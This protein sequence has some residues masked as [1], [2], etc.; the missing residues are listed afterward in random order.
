LWR[1]ILQAQPVLA[2]LPGQVNLNLSY[3]MWGARNPH[4]LRYSTPLTASLLF[5]RRGREILPPSQVPGGLEIAAPLKG[6]VA[7]ECVSAYTAA[8]ET[9]NQAL[10]ETEDGYVGEEGEVWY[11]LDE[12]GRWTMLK[13]KPELIEAVHWAASGIN[14]NAIIATCWNALENWDN[15]TVDQV[16]SL[17]LEEYALSEVEKVHHAIVKHLEGCACNRNSGLRSLRY[18]EKWG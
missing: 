4:L 12:T 16:K 8:R 14:K 18:T 11:L 2:E 13:C 17:L 5:A 3:E 9:M 15:P 10:R 7:A 6:V 1:E